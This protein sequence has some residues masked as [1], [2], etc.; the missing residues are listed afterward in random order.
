MA[1]EFSE[2][3]TLSVCAD[4]RAAGDRLR[5][6]RLLLGCLAARFSPWPNVVVRAGACMGV[7]GEPVAVAL[8]SPAR[9]TYLFARLRE[10]AGAAALEAFLPL[11]MARGG[12]MTREAER[13]QGLRGRLRARIAPAAAPRPD[14]RDGEV[15]P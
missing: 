2:S 12:G 10:E 13:P 3:M 7:C 14:V 11:Y 8:Q 6:G 15:V 4:C 1:R 5:P 9:A